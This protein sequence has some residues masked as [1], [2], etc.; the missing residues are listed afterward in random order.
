MLNLD[1]I[2][3]LDDNDYYNKCGGI[4]IVG[5]ILIGELLLLVLFEVWKLFL[6]F[7]WDCVFLL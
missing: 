4:E 7:L 6:F 5:L 3:Y 2:V 1:N